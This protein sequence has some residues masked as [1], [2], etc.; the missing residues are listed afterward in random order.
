MWFV[1][2]VI[3]NLLR[4]KIRSAVTMIGVALAVGSMVALVGMADQFERFFTEI[5]S[6][7]GADL[8]VLRAGVT[9]RISSLV[10]ERVGTRLAA[11]PEVARVVPGLVDIAAFEDG[12]VSNVSI[13][14]WPLQSPLFDDLT[15]LRGRR[16]QPGDKRMVMMGRI[17]AQRLGKDVGDTV[18]IDAVPFRVVGIYD[19]FNVYEN[20]GVVLPLTE[21]QDLTD[22][23]GKV[24]GFMVMLKPQYRN[25]ESMDR[26]CQNIKA[27]RDPRGRLLN[28]DALPTKEYVSTM[29]ELRSIKGMAWAT[30]IIALLIGGVAMFN[31]MVM[32]VFERTAELGILRGV[33]WRRWRVALLILSESAVLSLAGCALG[34]MLAVV[35]VWVLSL[36][37]NAQGLLTAD[38]SLRVIGL[39]V[40]LG[41]GIGS[42]SGLYPAMRAA[43]LPPTEAIRHE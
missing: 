36:M 33:G 22:R 23:P 15:V 40:L 2:L 7:R 20:G 28:L 3:R 21:L 9:Q 39:G 19:S 10:D 31:T 41:L 38:V 11:F 6:K 18:D 37:P 13:N 34:V 5:F 35:L 4:R 8:L 43:A 1:T 12:Q 27:L 30:T 17:L 42:V 26:L 24:N 32:S 25:R 14:G 16:L 29:V